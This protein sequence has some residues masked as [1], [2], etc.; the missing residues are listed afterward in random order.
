MAEKFEG[1]SV[2]ESALTT[3]MDPSGQPSALACFKNSA[4]QRA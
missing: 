2:V 3:V 4:W 1:D